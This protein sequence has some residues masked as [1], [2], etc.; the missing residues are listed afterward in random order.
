M[1]QFIL[2]GRDAFK[3]FDPRT[4]PVQGE[5]VQPPAR[6][7][8]H[9]GHFT[10]I[11][12]MLELVTPTLPEMWPRWQP[13]ALKSPESNSTPPLPPNG[14]SILPLQH[15][16]SVVSWYYYGIIDADLLERV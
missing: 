7:Q 5:L 9:Q 13:A 2:I 6:L 12:M 11:M 4:P 8:Q 10:I 3:M 1:V 16:R 14:P 15:I